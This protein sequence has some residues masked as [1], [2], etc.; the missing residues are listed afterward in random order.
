MMEFGRGQVVEEDGEMGYK[1]TFPFDEGERVIIIRQD[2]LTRLC[3][4]EIESLIN[5]GIDMPEHLYDVREHSTSLPDEIM[6][7]DVD[8]RDYRL[9]LD[10]HLY[11]DD[12]KY[13]AWI[14]YESIDQAEAEDEF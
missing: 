8:D 14:R 10:R 1:G 4:G 5:C 7:T 12:F 9:F 3:K 2:D 6:F 13:E 11:A